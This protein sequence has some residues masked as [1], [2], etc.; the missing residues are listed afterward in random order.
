MLAMAGHTLAYVANEVEE[1]AI[2]LARATN[3]DPNLLIARRWSGT[4]QLWLGD[5]DAAIEQF[6]TALRLSPLDPL[7][8]NTQTGLAV[9]FFSLAATRM[10]YSWATAATKT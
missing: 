6:K 10:R 4:I 2:L 1:G 9:A 3:L 5:G 8:F 7:I